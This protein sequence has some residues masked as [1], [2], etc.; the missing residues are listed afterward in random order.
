[1]G[2]HALELAVRG[3]EVVGLDLSRVMLDR[4][5][6]EARNR[7][8]AV[9]FVHADARK[10]SFRRLFDGVLLWGSSFGY[11]R[12]SENPP[13]LKKIAEALRPSGRL[14]LQVVNRDFYLRELPRCHWRRVGD[15]LILDEMELDSRSSRFRLR[16]SVLRGDGRERLDTLDFRAYGLH[17]LLDLLTSQGFTPLEVSGRITSRGVFLGVESPSIIVLAQVR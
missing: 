6:Q 12:D 15:A 16:R 4:A 3:Y 5:A 13:L 9:D 10:L 1:V 8:L 14:L 17:E 2:R 7:K 11:F